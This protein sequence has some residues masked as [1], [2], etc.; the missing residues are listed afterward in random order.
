MDESSRVGQR[1]FQLTRTFLLKVINALD[2]SPDNVRVALVLYSDEPRLE[3]SLDTFEDKSEV[4][5]YLKKLP[6]RGGQTYTGAAIDF[7]RKKVFTKKG[8]SRKRQG[9]QQVAVVITDGQSLD[10]FTEPASKL[11]RS[12]VTVYA[13]GTQ[14]ISE[15][16]QL[17]KIAS[18]PPRKH[19]TSLESFLQLSHIDWKIKK[20][21]CT[22]I[23]ARAFAVPVRSRNVKAGKDFSPSISSRYAWE[24]LLVSMNSGKG[25][26]SEVKYL[27]CMQTI[28]L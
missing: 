26:S 22:E 21:L 19:V 9:V 23:V 3:F 15:T 8:G 17:H 4:L 16:G 14:N 12:K 10:N 11:R 24:N 1:N 13:V 5:Q 2:I 27:F 7:L 25:C 20:R 18:Y 28:Q 6:Y